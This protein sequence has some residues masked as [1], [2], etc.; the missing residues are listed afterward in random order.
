[1]EEYREFDFFRGKIKLR[2]PKSHRLSVVE[3]LFVANLKGIRKSSKVLDLGAGF[4]ALSVLIAL[5]HLCPVWAVERDPLMLELLRENLR[6]NNI[7]DR[8]HL[9]ERDLRTLRGAFEPKCFDVVVAN[10]PFYKQSG[11]SD[12]YHHE[13]DTTLKDFIETGALFLRDG[14]YFN[15][16][17][18]SD[19]LV[20]ALSHMERLNMHL[21][22][23]RIFYPKVSKNGKIARIT[24]VKNLSP[25]PVVEKP[26]IINREEGGYTQEVSEIISSFL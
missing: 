3:V 6:L 9:L 2:Q 1:M 26:L 8:V 11:K 16:L 17:I 10:P 21:A 5:K 25:R 4:G 18:A 14:G 12:G 24:A 15:L 22:Y 7:E 13:S 20:E 19:R 23:L